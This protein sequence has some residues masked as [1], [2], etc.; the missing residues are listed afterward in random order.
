MREVASAPL[1]GLLFILAV[2]GKAIQ[3]RSNA[4]KDAVLLAAVPPGASSSSTIHYMD[5]NTGWVNDSAK[6]QHNAKASTANH[7]LVWP[8]CWQDLLRLKR[9]A[10]PG[11][12]WSPESS[13]RPSASL[14]ATPKCHQLC[15]PPARLAYQDPKCLGVSGQGWLPSTERV[16]SAACG[17]IW[18]SLVLDISPDDALP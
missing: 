7:F 4:K 8:H 16:A 13:W 12:W 18:F 1:N 2:L 10:R 11:S 15:E 6:Q 5:S 3:C 17:N 9:L 14:P